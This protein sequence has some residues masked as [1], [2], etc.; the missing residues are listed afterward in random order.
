ME[1][2]R[3]VAAGAGVE[4]RYGQKYGKNTSHS[5]N[6]FFAVQLYFMIVQYLVVM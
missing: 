2:L 6:E 5:L 3:R 1:H 4:K